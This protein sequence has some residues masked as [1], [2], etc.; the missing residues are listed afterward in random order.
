MSNYVE[1]FSTSERIL[2]WIVTCSFFILFLSGLGL[3]SRLFNGYFNLFGGGQ[4]AIL[5]HKAAGVLFFFTSLN[6][7]LNHKKDVSTFDEDDK[8]WIEQRGGYLSRDETHFNIGKYNPGQKL[9]AIFIAVAT[10]I[11]GI[12]GL[13]IWMPT[14]FPRWIVQLS[15]MLHGLMFAGSVMFVVMHIYLATIGN[16]GTIEAMLYGNIPKSWAR[17]HHPKWYKEVTG[18]S[19]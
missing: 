19:P 7:F 9:F 11:L 8:Q 5:I 16:P 14:F 2:H 18:E 15:L 12:T 13:F 6:M 4:N 17:K 3:Y 10:L 1:R